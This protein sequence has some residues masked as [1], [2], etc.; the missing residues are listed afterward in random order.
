MII[1]LIKSVNLFLVFI[2][3]LRSN[4]LFHLIIRFWFFLSAVF[5]VAAGALRIDGVDYLIYEM[6]FQYPDDMLIPDIGYRL[7]NFI[8]S[9][10]YFDYRFITISIAIL[11]LICVYRA[12]GYFN[13]NPVMFLA[14]YLI[15]F[16]LL[17]DFA[18]LRFAFAGYV[19]VLA[20]TIRRN[21]FRHII[22][23][24]SISI[25]Y[26]M[27]MLY[28]AVLLFFRRS[29][30]IWK[31]LALFMLLALIG[32]SFSDYLHIL[33]SRLTVYSTWQSEVDKTTIDHLISLLPIFSLAI[34]FGIN[35]AESEIIDLNY[36]L[37][38]IAIITYVITLPFSYIQGR[39]ASVF[40]TLYPLGLASVLSILGKNRS[41]F[42]PSKLLVAS[43]FL[44]HLLRVDTFAI[45]NALAW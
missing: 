15:H 41:L 1:F 22:L 18:Q 5:V 4:N 13:F 35:R 26:S 24:F 34:L 45:V 28:I 31:M 30:S 14:I 21:F 39:V 9:R 12:S 20:L 3:F 17:R 36:K 40:M 8:A 43:F 11:G 2:P 16:L 29:P 44:M 32:Q 27:V 42:V 6:Q 23:L 7:L 25:H 10:I 37:M 33:D 19:F 38:I